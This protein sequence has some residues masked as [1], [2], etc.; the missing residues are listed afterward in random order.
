MATDDERRRVAAALRAESGPSLTVLMCVLGV[1][2]GR[3]F[4]RLA[5]LIDPGDTSHN[6]RD[7]VASDPTERGIDSIHEW[8]FERLEGADGA[9]DFLYC[10][11]MSAIEEYRH[12]ERVTARTARPVDREALRA[13]A[14]GL[15]SLGDREVLSAGAAREIAD[16]IMDAIGETGGEAS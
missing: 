11:I 7:A 14:S 3:L 8:C 4:S 1:G 12:P 5:D 2:G 10:S 16:E 15:R 6:C 9:E 13:V